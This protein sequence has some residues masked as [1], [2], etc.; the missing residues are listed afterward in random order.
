VLLLGSALTVMAGAVI[1]PVV[2]LV[3]GE[4]GVSDTRVGLLLTVHALSLAAASPMVGRLVDRHGPRAPLTLGLVWYGLAG[5]GGALAE[6]FEALLFT[7]LL[8]GAGAA[9]V[10]VA[11]TVALLDAVPREAQDRT[12]G[13]RSTATSLG[14]VLCPLVG[15]IVAT[16]G[17]WAPFVVYLVALPL[18]LATWLLLPSKEAAPPI[19]TPRAPLGHTRVLVSLCCLFALGSAVL[20]VVIVFVPLRL[21]ELGA[22]S[23]LVAAASTALMSTAMS[24]TALAFAR[25][26]RRIGLVPV[27][28]GG[29][30]VIGCG[31]L[32]LASVSS[33]LLLVAAAGLFGA[34]FGV[35]LPALTILLSDAV[36]ATARGRAM[37]LSATALFLGQFLSPLLVGPPIERTSISFGFLGVGLAVLST[38]IFIVLRPPTIAGRSRRRA[39]LVRH[40]DDGSTA[41]GHVPEDGAAINVRRR[42]P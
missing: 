11:T 42:T 6:S 2:A 39:A 32:V 37:A 14:G 9:A 27:L 26:R 8:F 1:A 36:P 40:P 10:F 12:M 18:A 29:Y 28:A 5:G 22:R 15:G 23:P 19:R 35:T 38:S 13:W 31:L 24:I 21:H 25:L 3:Q 30:A 16:A 41:P 20:Y 7:R 34:G 4:F 17:W 33:P